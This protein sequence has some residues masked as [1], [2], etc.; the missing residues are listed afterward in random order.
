M[1]RYERPLDAAHTGDARLGLCGTVVHPEP[2]GAARGDHARHGRRVAGRGDGA[3]ADLCERG[4]R[5]RPLGSW[6]SALR[7][8]ARCADN[9]TVPCTP[10][11]AAACRAHDVHR[12]RD[13][14]CRYG[15]LRP[16]ALVAACRLLFLVTLGAADMVSVVVALVV[17]SALDARSHAG[18]RRRRQRDVHRHVQPAGRVRDRASPPPGLAR[19]PQWCWAAS[20]RCSPSRLR[21]ARFRNWRRSTA[22]T[23]FARRLRSKLAAFCRSWCGI[24]AVTEGQE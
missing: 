16:V 10:S 22:W 4:F 21:F 6:P 2:P 23:R 18:S 5:N 20:A 12:R 3:A 7:P 8:G 11:V 9:G 24:A 1:I 13:L 14:R 17:D 15:R 19:W